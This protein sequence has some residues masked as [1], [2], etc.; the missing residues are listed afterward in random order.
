ME[1]EGR[2]TLKQALVSFLQYGGWA[3]EG[4]ADP[5]AVLRAVLAFLSASS[6]SVV[7]V[8]LEDLWLET[9]PQNVPGTGEE[10]PNWHRK[11]R[12]PLEMFSQLPQ[13]VEVLKEIDRLRRRGGP[14]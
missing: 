14:S 4:S 5:Q 12:Y 1:R 3:A 2:Q 10:R 8:N 13:V 11:A 6:A 7:L 9:Q